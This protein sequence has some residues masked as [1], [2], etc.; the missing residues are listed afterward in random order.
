MNN[1]TSQQRH[2]AILYPNCARPSD[3]EAELLHRILKINFFTLD[4]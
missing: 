2:G 1:T 4:K 3:I